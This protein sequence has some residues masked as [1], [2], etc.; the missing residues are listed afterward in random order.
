MKLYAKFSLS[1][2]KVKGVNLPIIYKSWRK[3]WE[4]WHLSV[5]FTTQFD[6]ETLFRAFTSEALGDLNPRTFLN[7]QTQENFEKIYCKC[8]LRCSFVYFELEAPESFKVLIFPRRTLFL[9]NFLKYWYNLSSKFLFVISTPS[10]WKII[11][12]CSNLSHLILFSISFSILHQGN[13]ISKMKKAP[14]KILYWKCNDWIVKLMVSIT[15]DVSYWYRP[16]Y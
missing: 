3:N 15:S 9:I 14:S 11:R 16:C 1:H 10:V 4:F 6:C 2:H 7:F 12:P 13:F 5:Y 8:I